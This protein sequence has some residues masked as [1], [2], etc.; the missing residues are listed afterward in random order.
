MFPK[1]F[2]STL[3]RKIKFIV[4]KNFPDSLDPDKWRDVLKEAASFGFDA[5]YLKVGEG[6]DKA[7]LESFLEIIASRDF[8]TE[9]DDQRSW[10][11]EEAVFNGGIDLFWFTFYGLN[12]ATHDKISGEGG[13]Q[14]VLEKI[15]I[16]RGKNLPYGFRYILTNEN[17]DESFGLPNYLRNLEYQPVK[18]AVEE[19]SPLEGAFF[20]K[21]ML[22]TFEQMKLYWPYLKKHLLGF[23]QR[24]NP[25]VKI[26]SNYQN[27]EFYPFF[28]GAEMIVEENGDVHSIPLFDS[29]LAGNV[30]TDPFSKINENLIDDL[31]KITLEK[32]E[33]GLF[34]NWDSIVTNRPEPKEIDFQDIERVILPESL[35]FLMNKTCN[36]RCDFCE[37]DCKPED[38]Q[39]ID[40]AD[41][42]KILEEAKKLGI[43]QM[44]FDG[45]EPLIHPDIK[46]AF[47]VVGDL[48]YGA[49]VLT[50]GWRFSEFL[51]DYRENNIKKFIFGIYG[52]SADTHDIIVGEK[53]SFDRCVAAIKLS[54]KL[55]Y[56]TGLHTVLHP[57]NFPEL[58]RFFDLAEQWQVDYI[59][60]SLIMPVGRAKN[61]R[62]IL[63]SQGAK[64][65]L[66]SIY[67]RHR[68]FLSKITFLGHQPNIG[69]SFACKYLNRS[70]HLS[71]HWDGSA[72]L[73]ALTPLLNLP[74]LKIKD[75]SLID[76][77]IFMNKVSGDFQ[78]TE[79]RDFLNWQSETKEV[80]NCLFCHEKL[81][82]GIKKYTEAK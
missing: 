79:K 55:G 53:G 10:T 16:L 60:A 27:M 23:P 66:A 47:K 57:L 59:M 78:K 74:F 80:Q 13:Y 35:S 22:V 50:N 76:C 8:S 77:M 65:K 75:H 72:A 37:F 54:K 64:E 4:S 32:A 11:K 33:K 3:M 9:I 6:A 34:L 52:A 17:I 29:L 36:L 44:V 63:L 81:S 82:Q 69:R 25:N 70:S 58:D 21:E 46:K 39:M 56:F 20:K 1:T 45:G 30:L 42:K 15:E 31:N 73:C 18:I 2:L 7:K 19:I 43:K 5:F 71:I 41:F 26:Y 28:S 49:T 62:N 48:G 12:S 68:D 24:L 67:Q 40:M 51:N 14:A 38:G 61:N